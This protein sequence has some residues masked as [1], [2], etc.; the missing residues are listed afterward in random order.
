[1]EIEYSDC[2]LKAN[3]LGGHVAFVVVG[4]TTNVGT[5]R[6]QEVHATAV[7]GPQAVIAKN[8]PI[9]LVTSGT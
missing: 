7:V 3:E 6:F 2:T 8:P 4:T 5:I 1:L 9:G